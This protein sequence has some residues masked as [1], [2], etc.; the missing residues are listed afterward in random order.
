MKSIIIYVYIFATHGLTI[1]NKPFK[2]FM[3]PKAAPSATHVATPCSEPK[4]KTAK[5][6]LPVVGDTVYINHLKD[7]AEAIGGGWYVIEPVETLQ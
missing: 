1:T 2:H 3:H 7:T 6:H 4:H 5:D